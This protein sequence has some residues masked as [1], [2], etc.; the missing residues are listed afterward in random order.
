MGFVKCPFCFTSGYTIVLHAHTHTHF[1]TVH[2][3][4]A[5]CIRNGILLPGV[6][7]WEVVLRLSMQGCVQLAGVGQEHLHLCSS[8][9]RQTPALTAVPALHCTAVSQALR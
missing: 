1:N 5:F 2:Y 9:R 3:T 7:P 8:G 6:N 4:P